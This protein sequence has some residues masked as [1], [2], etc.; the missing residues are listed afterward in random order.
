[1]VSLWWV[2]ERMCP[3]DGHGEAPGE[4]G[5][6]GS[7]WGGW[8]FLSRLVVLFV[9]LGISGTRRASSFYAAGYIDDIGQRHQP[10]PSYVPC[11]IRL[12]QGR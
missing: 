5:Y 12:P 4:L 7:R 1:V 8:D 6:L 2:V 9:S 3:N 10:I 11:Y